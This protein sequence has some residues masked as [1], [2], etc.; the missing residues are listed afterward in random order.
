MFSTGTYIVFFQNSESVVH[1]GHEVNP[2]AASF[3]PL[4]KNKHVQHPVSL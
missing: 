1:I 2:S 3:T 4:K